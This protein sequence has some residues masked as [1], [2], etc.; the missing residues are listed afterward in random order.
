MTDCEGIEFSLQKLL[1]RRQSCDL[2]TQ[3]KYYK[4]KTEV[5]KGSLLRKV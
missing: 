1:K 2:M 3:L 5:L 4:V